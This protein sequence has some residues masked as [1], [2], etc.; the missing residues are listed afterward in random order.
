MK[1]TPVE[2]AAEALEHFDMISEYGDRDLSDQLVIDAICMRLSAGIE[3]LSRLEHWLRDRAFASAWPVMWGMRNRIA[4]GY[5]MVNP[6]IV[7]R[8]I[9]DDLPAI[10]SRTEWLI[11]DGGNPWPEESADPG[12][13]R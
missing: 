6:E 4:H 2:I 8:T 11:E 1:Q 7:R 13:Q 10:R 5:L 9:S 12:Q 3:V